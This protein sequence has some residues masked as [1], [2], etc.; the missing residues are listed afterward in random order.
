MKERYTCY[1]ELMEDYMHLCEE[2]ALTIEAIQELLYDVSLTT[3]DIRES[4]RLMNVR[5]KHCNRLME[6]MPY[7]YTANRRGHKSY[8]RVKT[9][10]AYRWFKHGRR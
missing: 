6:R 10:S 2:L 8:K 1:G 4:L 3:G 9:K 7:A 5:M